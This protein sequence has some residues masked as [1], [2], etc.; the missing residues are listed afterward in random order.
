MDR[1]M[2]TRQQIDPKFFHV[3]K[4]EKLTL[5]GFDGEHLSKPS[6]VSDVRDA[7]LRLLEGRQC[8]TLVVDLM[9]VTVTSSWVLGV[10][11]ALR[12]HGV[13]VELYHPSK[14]IKDVLETTHLDTV[15]HVRDGL[16]GAGECE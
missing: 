10:F 3:Y 2:A 8:E 6:E 7:L 4:T 5:V 15:L 11:A 16:E 12:Q 13:A 14:V 9:D 1:E